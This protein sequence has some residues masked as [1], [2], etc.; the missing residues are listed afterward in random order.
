MVKQLHFAEHRKLHN[1]EKLPWIV[2][3]KK[4]KAES[5]VDAYIRAIQ[6]ELDAR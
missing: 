1:T 2:N 4:S 6:N 5:V 3:K